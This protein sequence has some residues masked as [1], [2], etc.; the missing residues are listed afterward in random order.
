MSAVVVVPL[1]TDDEHRARAWTDVSGRLAADGWP[2]LVGPNVSELWCKSLAVSAAIVPTTPEDVL[3]VH[4]ADVL[5]DL[6]ALRLAVAHVESGGAWAIPHREVYRLTE[7][8]TARY[9]ETRDVPMTPELTRWPYIGVEGG[10]VCV[11][12]RS[13]Y[14]SIPIDPRFLGWGDEDHCWGWALRTLLGE[15]WRSPERLVH[16]WHPH[17]APGKQ[18]SPRLESETMRRRYRFAFDDPVRMRALVDEVA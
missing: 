4:D 14:D 1:A 2:V 15:P 18:R 6:S 11:L 3:V 17:S 5:V 9:Y 10:G 7:R 13:T 8:A 12:R 16:L